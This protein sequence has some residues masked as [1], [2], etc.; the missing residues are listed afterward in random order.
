M[1]ETEVERAGNT[2]RERCFSLG[3]LPLDAELFA[4]AIREHWPIENRPHWMLD[5]VFHEDLSRL[6]SGQGPHNMATVRH[7]ALDL[8]RGAKDKQSLKVRRKSAAW[9]GACREAIMRQT[10]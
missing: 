1:V 5:V 6:R 3:S 2:R 4:G 10:A 9:D 7:I 8:L